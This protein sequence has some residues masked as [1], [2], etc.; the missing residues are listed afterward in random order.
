MRKMG[1]GEDKE[2]GKEMMW[3]RIE[4]KEQKW[5]MLERKRDLRGRKKRIA[6]D[7]TWKERKIRWRLRE[8]ARLE[9]REKN[10]I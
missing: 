2:K 4:N 9:E 8:K 5:K 7:L 3:V 1:E 6:E 10:R